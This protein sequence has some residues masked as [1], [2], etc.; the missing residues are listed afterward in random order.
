MLFALALATTALAANFFF[1]KEAIMESFKS[2]LPMLDLNI[3]PSEQLFIAR[4]ERR[5]TWDIH[6]YFGI[7][8]TIL[9]TIWVAINFLKKNSRYLIFKSF[10]FS[11]STK[12]IRFYLVFQKV[13]RTFALAKQK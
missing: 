3:T 12:N 8:F 2:S 10:F 6:L 9:L 11:I 13:V 1:S 5:E 7:L 4:I